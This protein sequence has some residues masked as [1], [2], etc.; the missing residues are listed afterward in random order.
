MTRHRLAA[1]PL[2]FGILLVARAAHGHEIDSVSLSLTEIAAP[3]AHRDFFNGV[4]P[5][6]HC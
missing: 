2:V 5:P 6:A 4:E 1:L 3:T